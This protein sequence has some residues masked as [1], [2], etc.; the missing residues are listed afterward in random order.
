MKTKL[1]KVIYVSIE[2][3]GTSDEYLQVNK[4]PAEVAE[5]GRD[6]QIGEY[7]LISTGIVTATSAFKRHKN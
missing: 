1:P 2:N 7:R 4:Q 5:I 3:E 6:V